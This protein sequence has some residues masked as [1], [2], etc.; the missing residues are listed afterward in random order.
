MRKSTMKILK[1]KLFLKTNFSL[2]Y[3]VMFKRTSY[4]QSFF[5]TS[6]FKTFPYVSK[7]TNKKRL[8]RAFVTLGTWI[9]L[10]KKQ[11]ILNLA[12]VNHVRFV[13]FSVEDG[14]NFFKNDTTEQ[15]LFEYTKEYS[16]FYKNNFDSQKI[17]SNFSRF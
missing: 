9:N 17:R 16:I 4:R 7:V 13:D 10:S 8:L 5:K 14:D 6:F 11:R 3:R 2:F 15:L 1:K 12:S